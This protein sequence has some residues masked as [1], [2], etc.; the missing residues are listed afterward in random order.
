MVLSRDHWRPVPLLALVAALAGL[1]SA[2]LSLYVTNPYPRVIGLL[3]FL[4]ALSWSLLRV[5]ETSIGQLQVPTGLFFG[6]YLWWLA[7]TVLLFVSAGYERTLLVHAALIVLFVLALSMVVVTGSNT[8]R[9]AVLVTTGVV[10]RATAYYASSLQIGNDAIWHTRI[11]S[12]I[13]A[14]GTLEPLA[15]TGSKYWF[16]PFHHLLVAGISS[17]G[18]VSTRHAAFL[19]VTVP[20]VV[21]PPLTIYALLSGLGQRTVGVV[22]AWLYLVADRAVGQSVHVIPTSTGVLFAHAP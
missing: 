3:V 8:V 4:G 9:L 13:A 5:R 22:A 17:V 19:A 20:L 16:M 12:E 2:L 15:A 10:Q 11:A 21:I 18:H 6:V 7:A 1:V 14:S